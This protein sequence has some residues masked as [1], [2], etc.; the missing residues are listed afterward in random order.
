MTKLHIGFWYLSI[1]IKTRLDPNSTYKQ[2]LYGTELSLNKGKYQFF[3]KLSCSKL[4]AGVLA[5]AATTEDTDTLE[6]G[7]HGL[8]LIFHKRKEVQRV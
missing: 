5:R 8:L 3:A 1:L 2:R 6:P 7:F 4:V